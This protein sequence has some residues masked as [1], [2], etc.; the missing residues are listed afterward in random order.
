MEKHKCVDFYNLKLEVGQE[1]IPICS[2]ALLADIKGII[3]KTE[4]SEFYNVW[5]ID[6]SDDK[7]N[8]LLK[9]VNPRNYT[10][11]ERFDERESQEYVF[12]L[13]FYDDYGTYITHIPLTN[14]TNPNY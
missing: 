13:S 4:Y 10:T 9:G 2:D 12:S 6:I 14:V 7:G 5:F 11:Q 3:S 8:L 1:V